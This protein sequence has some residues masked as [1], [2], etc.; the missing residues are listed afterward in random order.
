MKIFASKFCLKKLVKKSILGK[1]LADFQKFFG[2]HIS[3]KS[4]APK[5]MNCIFPNGDYV[6]GVPQI[7]VFLVLAFQVC[8]F[9]STFTYRIFPNLSQEFWGDFTK[10]K[11]G[12]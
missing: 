4:E 9:L 11:L 1:V 7:S 8:M 5:K 6:L 2:E 3:L 10:L 12:V